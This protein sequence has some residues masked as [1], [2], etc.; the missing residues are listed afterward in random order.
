[1]IGIET[2]LPLFHRIAE[3]ADFRAGR[4]NVHWLERFVAG[5]A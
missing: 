4:Y 2:T 3:S 5:T 1:M